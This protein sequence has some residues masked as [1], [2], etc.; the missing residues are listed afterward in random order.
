LVSAGKVGYGKTRQQVKTM[1]E[2]IAKERGYFERTKFQMDGGE[3]TYIERQP[4]L[5]LCHADSTAHIQMDL[6]NKKSITEYFNFLDS[7]LKENH[8]EDCPGQI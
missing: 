6:I 1:V 3:G 7:M 8:L 4:E 2:A 5:C